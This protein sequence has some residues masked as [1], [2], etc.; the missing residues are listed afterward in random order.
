MWILPSAV[1]EAQSGSS[2]VSFPS[3]SFLGALFFL[4]LSLKVPSLSRVLRL[5]DSKNHL[6]L[7]LVFF[8]FSS[9]LFQVRR[10][11]SSL[12]VLPMVTSGKP[13]R[14]GVVAL[15]F[16]TKG[17]TLCRSAKEVAMS[18]REMWFVF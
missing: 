11:V 7:L 6:S 8:C 14:R 15:P 4:F 2:W 18:T 12:A 16:L 17:C 5:F 13:S 3:S 1:L 9:F 10:K